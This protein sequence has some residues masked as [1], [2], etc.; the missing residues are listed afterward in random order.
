MI[1]NNTLLEEV[2]TKDVYRVLDQVPAPGTHDT[3]GTLLVLV[4][5]N[6]T[7]LH[8]H[9]ES[10]ATI[11]ERIA[12]RS[13][14]AKEEI[15]EP[16]NMDA[17]SAAEAK[18]VARRRGVI[19]FVMAHGRRV[20]EPSFRGQL[21]NEFEQSGL[22]S[23]PF[24]YKTLRIW[25]Q[26][27][28]VASS[29]VTDFPNC[30]RK[31][32]RRVQEHVAKKPGRPRSIQPGVGVAITLTHLM[33]M[34]LAWSRSP[35]GTDGRNLRSAYTWMLKARYYDLL[36]L[37]PSKKPQRKLTSAPSPVSDGDSLTLGA[38]LE[39]QVLNYDCVPTFEQF[40]YHWQK[41]FSYSVRKLNR[42]QRR[43]FDA[44]FKPLLSGTLKE[45]RGPG[46]RFY[47]DATVLDV[48]CVSRLNRNR[49]VGR[50]TLYIVADEFS[51]MVVGMYV[52][53]EPPCWVGAMLALWNC[54][55]DK[56]K[57][58]AQYGIEIAPDE[59]PTGFMPLHFMG[60]RGELSALMAELLSLAFGL[61]VENSRAYAGEAK[62]V[63]ERVFNTV[64]T[65]FGPFMPGYVDKEFSGR[66]ASPA[67]LR[68]A[69]DIH[70]ITRTVI[71]AVLHSNLRV[72]RGYEGW[73]E[74]IA[75][76]VPFVPVELWHW[77]VNNLRCD[78]RQF[79]SAYLTRNL[80]PSATMKFSRNALQFYRGLYFMG[81]SLQDEPWFAEAFAKRAEVNT[82]FNPGNITNA[83]LIPPNLR[84]GQI[85]IALTRRSSRFSGFCY[86]EVVALGNDAK[87]Q[88][89]MAAWEN[90]PRQVEHEGQ[91]HA[92]IRQAKRNWREQYDDSLSDAA[93]KRGI[94]DNRREEIASL[95][96]ES[97]GLTG[98]FE[99]ASHP[100]H[101]DS[102]PHQS[103]V[104]ETAT[105][106]EQL[107]ADEMRRDR[108]APQ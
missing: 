63:V 100:L 107:L 12:D 24:F 28:C 70:E 95:T 53:L 77:G 26:G 5:V 91:M 64:Q 93:R 79:D 78:V 21:A 69:M 99:P 103:A 34:R 86:S 65:K 39:P 1:P 87:R 16:I 73:P 11:A 57:F 76:G 27:G 96:A 41:E 18:T 19:D 88:N 35:V 58:C 14:V 56:V 30:G 15:K 75:D 13:L 101:E 32:E 82:R 105:E 90:L 51:R 38:A 54:S 61:D 80:W 9:L 29:L 102:I 44:A 3:A 22:G 46:T 33:N 104:Q 84:S 6:G 89:A 47:I 106:V 8:L 23:R 45:V 37:T 60:D 40:R 74:V 42:L 85:D 17:L 55:L 72:V 7:Q 49:I 10:K 62:G 68:A 108:T 83:I 94:K 98:D 97:L 20:F 50:P 71:L 43:R 48:Y 66:D 59:W 2:E 31:G 4:K 81:T 92:G 52:G 25:F 67:E 36:I